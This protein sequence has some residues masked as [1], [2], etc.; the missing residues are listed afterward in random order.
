MGRIGP[1]GGETPQLTGIYTSF[2]T[3]PVLPPYNAHMLGPGWRRFL[4]RPTALEYASPTAGN[5]AP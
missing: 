5:D 1:P 4:E 2:R 3:W